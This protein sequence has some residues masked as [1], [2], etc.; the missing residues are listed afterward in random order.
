MNSVKTS[1]VGVAKVSA[2]N[3]FVRPCILSHFHKHAAKQFAV[4]I[5]GRHQ[6][7]KLALQLACQC[8]VGTE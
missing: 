1:C 2:S 4:L 8:T 7:G 5:L 6:V 3:N